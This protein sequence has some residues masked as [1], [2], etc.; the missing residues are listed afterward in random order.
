[1]DSEVLLQTHAEM[2]IAITGF[3]SVIAALSRPLTAFARQR[4]FSLLALSVIQ[5]LGCL[6]PLWFL[7]LIESPST[8]WRLASIIIL[9]LSLVRLRWLVFLPLRSLGEEAR[10]ILNPLARRLIYGGGYLGFACLALNSIGIGFRPN[11]D[12][13]YASLLV[14]LLVGFAL[15]ADVATKES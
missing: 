6:I 14:T 2:A 8:V 15:F 5:I 7:H 4:F 11:F 3:A 1:M 12:L 9:V 13:Y 10:N